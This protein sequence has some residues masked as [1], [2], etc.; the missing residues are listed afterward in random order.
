MKAGGRGRSA[1]PVLV[2]PSGQTGRPL[3]I[4]LP[5]LQPAPSASGHPFRSTLIVTKILEQ[6]LRIVVVRR[7]RPLLRRLRRPAA[8]R[9]PPNRIQPYATGA[10]EQD[11]RAKNP[12]QD[13]QP[14]PPAPRRRQRTRIRHPPFR[15]GRR[16]LR[17]RQVD[18]RRHRR[19]PRK[20]VVRG[21]FGSGR[22]HRFQTRPTIRAE[23]AAVG[24]GRPAV[25]TGDHPDPPSPSRARPA[26]PPSRGVRVARRRAPR[27][28]LRGVP[29]AYQSGSQP[30]ASPG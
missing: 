14:L 1:S 2:L 13:P 27:P 30:P 6:L 22:R 17:R 19:R 12:S 8:N 4:C 24:I 29:L 11:A 21:R 16:P 10:T 26:R 20:P 23:P 28:Q 3:G 7:R 15:I 18:R 5:S 25:R 9:V